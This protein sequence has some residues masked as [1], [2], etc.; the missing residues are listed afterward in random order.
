MA[1]DTKVLIGNR[2]S[3]PMQLI[4]AHCRSLQRRLSHNGNNTDHSI[5][6]LVDEV[7][8][9][10][11]DYSEPDHTLIDSSDSESDDE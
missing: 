8:I 11:D 9:E 2:A 1:E 5:A 10:D 7:I 6:T 4:A 3:D